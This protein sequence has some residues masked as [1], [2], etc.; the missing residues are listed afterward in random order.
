MVGVGGGC[1]FWAEDDLVSVGVLD[2]VVAV[3]LVPAL[4]DKA[5]GLVLEELDVKLF[6]G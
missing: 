5:D 6:I 2:K 3:M 4:Q 1:W